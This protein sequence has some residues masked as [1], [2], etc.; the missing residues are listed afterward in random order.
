VPLS[1]TVRLRHGRYD[2]ADE[3]PSQA[4]WPPHPARVFC[5]L[6]A[7]LGGGAAGAALRWL[8]AQPAPEI[9]ADPLSSVYRGKAEGYV[10]KNATASK[11]VGGS[12]AWPGRSSGKKVR[13]F[14]VPAASSFSLVW[15]QSD[16]T[17]EVLGQL[18][19]LAR[20]V[21]YV[22]RSTSLA[23][24]TAEDTVPASVP[25]QVVCEA[26]DPGETRAAFPVRVPYP[27]YM[28]ELD[29]AYL[30]GRRSWET[31]RTVSYTVRR[32]TSAPAD[33]GTQT[34]TGPLQGPFE[35]L[36]VWALERPTAR[37]DGSHAAAVA[38]A[39]RRAVMSRVQDPVP[40]QVSGHGAAGRPHVGF[41][42]L[43][44]VGHNHADGH[45]LGLA[46]AVPHGLPSPDL[47]SLLQAVV[48]DPLTRLRLPGGSTL[49]LRY[50]ADRPGLQPERWSR[51]SREWVTVTPLM[52]DGYLRHGRDEASEVARSLVIAGYPRPAEVQ[53]S[54][55]PLAPGAVWRPRPSTLPSGRPHRRL[56][57]ASVKFDEPLTG[58]VLAGAMRYLGLGL[59]LPAATAR[60]RA[61]RIPALSLAGQ[62]L[63]PVADRAGGRQATA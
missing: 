39:L 2:A 40:P 7:S 14:A 27:G 4:E 43:P 55:S 20:L 51:P 9:W 35:N 12:L 3:R 1:I 34:P 10:V 13:A 58:P 48:M 41:L 8:E 18:R 52:L 26:A 28:G 44:D 42:A 45:I 54:P 25:G 19:D 17:P 57:H 23:E 61:S 38:A 53:V 49:V 6:V 33:V 16:P 59:F 21:P 62:G 50:G 29:A 22:G 63:S 32:R 46:V 24:V 5:A 56:V 11:G 31:A 37:I 60:P 36:M 30:D 15:R 47:A